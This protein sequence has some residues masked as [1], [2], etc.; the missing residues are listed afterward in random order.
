MTLEELKQKLEA[1]G[2]RARMTIRVREGEVA[3]TVR[4]EAS[5]GWPELLA[6][7]YSNSLELAVE[8]ALEEAAEERC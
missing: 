1:L 4:D 2:P 6:K 8:H 3:V 5:A 7:T